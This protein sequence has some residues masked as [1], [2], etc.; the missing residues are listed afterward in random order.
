MATAMNESS[1][2]A[3]REPEWQRIALLCDKADSSP[4]ALTQS[5]LKEFI[6]LYRNVSA[7]L[8]A[9]RTQSTNLPMQMFL[10]D[11]VGRAH[12]ILYQGRRRPLL[13]TLGCNVVNAVRTVRRRRW[14]I[15]ASALFF[16]V[17]GLFLFG[18]LSARPDL[19]QQVIV[20]TGFADVFKDWTSGQLP[21][22]TSGQS[23]A[24]WGMYASHNPLVAI[25]SGSIAASTFGIGTVYML[26]QNGVLLGALS[27]EMMRVHKLGFLYQ[28]IMPHGVPE[29][30]GLIIS[31][32][33]G[34]CMGW[35]L[36]NPGRKRRGEALLEAGK[37]AI[38]LLATSVVMMLIAAPIEGFF[39]FN[40]RI[41]G[42]LKLAVIV[43]EVLAWGFF[44]TNFAK[45]PPEEAR[46]N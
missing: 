40:A 22:R 42:S 37:D 41:P 24:A 21:E 45:E 13:E 10:N 5:E 8:A 4:T 16:V 39:S 28:S 34:L 2:V 46:P 35:A 27:Y 26:M 17:T 11:L 7:D 19:R 43:V 6:R 12:G 33:A 44:W 3:R 30:S 29:L 14:F 20:D 32:A 25:V 36:I 1:F 18:V 15:L 23:I 38:T 9:V 31:G